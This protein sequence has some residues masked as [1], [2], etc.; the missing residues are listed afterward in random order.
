VIPD[1]R[2]RPATLADIPHILRHRRAMFRDMGGV[3]EAQLDAVVVTAEGFLR[4]GIPTGAYRG[5]LAITADG[6]IAAGAGITIVPWPGS[7]RDPAPRRGWIQ[8]VY[9]EPEFRR[10][11]LARKLMETVVEWCRADGFYAI[12]LHA[13]REGR[14][15]YE[16]IGFH[17]TNEMRLDLIESEAGR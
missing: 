2:I 5:W 11:G 8:N 7:P 3:T 17:D 15:L 13:S 4:E 10:Q 12:S 6:R 16:S 9:T 14:P 1:I